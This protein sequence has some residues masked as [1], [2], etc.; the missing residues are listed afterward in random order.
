MATAERKDLN[1]AD[2][3]RVFPKGKAELIN[4]GGGLLAPSYA[5]RRTSSITSRAGCTW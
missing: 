2:E 1:V 4:I 3:T 5:R